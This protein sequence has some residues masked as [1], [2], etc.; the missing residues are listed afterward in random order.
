LRAY[1]EDA[2]PYRDV[3]LMLFQHGVPSAG[4]A[5]PDQWL[6]VAS[7]R[8]A[9]ARLLG[10]DPRRFPHDIATIARYGPALDALPDSGRPWTPLDVETVVQ[11]LRR[12]SSLSVVTESVPAPTADPLLA[13]AERVESAHR[14]LTVEPDGCA[15]LRTG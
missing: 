14:I 11:S 6:R 10:L 8:G 9:R 13:R 1:L 3:D 2:V 4:I 7:A 5:D 15:S 12:S